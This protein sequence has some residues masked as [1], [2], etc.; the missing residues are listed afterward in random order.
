MPRPAERK[1]LVDS[2]RAHSKVTIVRADG[3]QVTGRAV[4]YNPKIDAWVINTGG[5]YGTPEIADD[6][7]V[8]KVSD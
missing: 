2:I 8:I 6:S 5:R 4:M 7:N 3:S 1:R